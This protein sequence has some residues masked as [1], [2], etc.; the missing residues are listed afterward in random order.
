MSDNSMTTR[1][2]LVWPLICSC[3]AF[4]FGCVSGHGSGSQIADEDWAPEVEYPEFTRGQGPVVLVDAAHG[5]FHT[6]DGRFGAFAELLR[7]DG[8]RVQS[9]DTPVSP[10]LLEQARIFVIS[11]AVYGGHDAEWLLPTPPAFTRD[12]IEVFVAWVE[13]GGSLLLIA[14]HMP[15]PGAT[16]NLANAFG[17]VFLNGFAMESVE[18][19]GI[20]TFTRSSGS[21]ADHGVTRGRSDAESIGSV[22]TFTGQAFRPVAPMQALMHMPDDWEVLLPIEAWE[23]D[24]HT[25]RVSARGLIQGGTLNFGSG[26]VAVFGE[27]AMFTAQS[28]VQDGSVMRMGMN[29][30]SAGE[31]PQFVLN[32]MHWLSGLLDD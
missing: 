4:C 3:M 5:N 12:E 27:A 6:I 28:Y 24:E 14:D 26:R 2:F 30:P 10:E 1:E 23:F 17:I 29:H 21:L 11:N 13:S 7:N 20:L 8:Y 19:G 32:I 15:F 9:A 22:M 31:N 25:P 18:E 16:A